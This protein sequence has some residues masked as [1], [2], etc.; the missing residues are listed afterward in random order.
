V[1]AT[2]EFLLWINGI[3]EMPPD[4]CVKTLAG[5]GRAYKESR[6]RIFRLVEA[7]SPENVELLA[8]ARSVVQ[9]EWRDLEARGFNGE[10]AARA[11]QIEEIIGSAEFFERIPL[12]SEAVECI[13]SKFRSLYEEKHSL[14]SSLY[15]TAVEEIRQRPEWTDLFADAA[16]RSEL[17]AVDAPLRRRICAGVRLDSTG[18]NC[19]VCRSSLGEIEADIQAVDALKATVIEALARIV[20]PAERIE[21]V[22]VA[23]FLNGTLTTPEEVDAVV[24][25]LRDHLRKLVNTGVRVIIE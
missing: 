7:T 3:L 19:S 4:D 24:E 12:L 14:R 18:P 16:R 20:E 17:E 15:V 8:R 10:L 25:R 13:D 6:A 22:K 5:E 2:E 9:S 23:S 21:R 11:A 1:E